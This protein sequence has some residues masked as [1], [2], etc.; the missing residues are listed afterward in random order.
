MIDP[1]ILRNDPDLLRESQRRRG[2][3]VTIIDQLIDADVAKR[4]A[5][6]RFDELRSA[7]KEIGKQIGPLQ[8][9]LK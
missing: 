8:G 5:G 2:E 9:S 1:S 3:D 6:M 7:Q 4:A